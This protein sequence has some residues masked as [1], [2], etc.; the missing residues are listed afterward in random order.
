MI[1]I[2]DEMVERACIAWDNWVIQARIGYITPNGVIK[3]TTRAS[4]KMM[5]VALQA[6]LQK[7]QE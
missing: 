2:T 6:A 5:R 4:R 3:D 1:E 7:E